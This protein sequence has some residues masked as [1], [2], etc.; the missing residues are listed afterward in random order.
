MSRRQEDD[1]IY[2]LQRRLGTQ[3]RVPDTQSEPMSTQPHRLSNP[4]P[5]P[6]SSGLGRLFSWRVRP[7]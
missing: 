1:S 7:A 4:Q 6:R 5:Q 2:T 3:R